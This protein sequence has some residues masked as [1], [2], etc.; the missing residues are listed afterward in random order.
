MKKLSILLAAVMSCN[1]L[2]AAAA[3]TASAQTLDESI[4]ASYDFNAGD[5]TTLPTGLTEKTS[6]PCGGYVTVDETHGKSMKFAASNGFRYVFPSDAGNVVTVSFEVNKPKDADARFHVIN[7]SD[8]TKNGN[9]QSMFTLAET[10]ADF[11]W[12]SSRKM[13]EIVPGCWYQVD[14]VIENTASGSTV[15]EYV[16]GCLMNTDTDLGTMSAVSFISTNANE[17]YV[18]NLAVRKGEYVTEYTSLDKTFD[19]EYGNNKSGFSHTGTGAYATLPMGFTRVGTLD[20]TSY[21][22][23]VS[24]DSEHGISLSSVNSSGMYYDIPVSAQNQTAKL[25]FELRVADTSD[26]GNFYVK[27][28]INTDN[29]NWWQNDALIIVKSGNLYFADAANATTIAKDEWVKVDL[30]MTPNADKADVDCYVNGNKL[31]SKKVPRASLTKLAFWS[32]DRSSATYI[33]NVK[34][35]M[36]F[37]AGTFTAS[38]AKKT[39]IPEKQSNMAAIAFDSSVDKSTF[40]DSAVTV[41]TEDGAAVEIDYTDWNNYANEFRIYLTNALSYAS[42][43][44]ITLPEGAKS[45][46]GETLADNTVTISTSAKLADFADFNDGT[47]PA[48]ITAENAATFGDGVMTL[49]AGENPNWCNAYYNLPY[50]VTEGIVKLSFDHY[51]DG[52]AGTAASEDADKRTNSFLKFVG[53][54]TFGAGMYWL[55]AGEGVNIVPSINW[56]STGLSTWQNKTWHH[57]DLIFDLDNKTFEL[58]MDGTKGTVAADKYASS[59]TQFTFGMTGKATVNIDNLSVKYYNKLGEF[60][61]DLSDEV[62][63]S[64]QTV[65]VSFKDA[66]DTAT[67]ENITLTD[68]KGNIVDTAEVTSFTKYNAVVTIGTALKQNEKYTFSLNGVKTLTGDAYADT[69]ITFIAVDKFAV[70]G[71]RILDGTTVIDA[72]SKWNASKEYTISADVENSSAAE[73]TIYVI[74]A[75]YNNGVLVNCKF[76]PVTITSSGTYTETLGAVDMKNATTIRIFAFNSFDDLAPILAPAITLN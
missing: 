19:F 45:V 63:S 37:E 30:V 16:D 35:R 34:L 49:K 36:P 65:N 76:V 53:T 64:K 18:D 27:S 60:E 24:Q 43:Y 54:N 70:T 72:V 46:Y 44:T 10:Y 29:N 73:K 1:M 52:V 62:D 17:V 12:W 11:E 9:G 33:D 32:K 14:L 40:D 50:E 26:N 51:V 25:S 7:D 59:L 31:N 28:G 20:A 41:T 61:T 23:Y 38:S 74:A 69:D 47:R 66:V 21:S 57:Y 8:G 13:S 68:S 48:R 71:V 3:V 2:A 39:I 4:I 67:L 6:Y 55:E 22:Q 42:S 56:A 15:K 58:Y 75:G 5:G